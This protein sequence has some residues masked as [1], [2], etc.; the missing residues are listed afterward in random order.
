MHFAAVFI[1]VLFSFIS[2]LRQ[3]AFIMHLTKRIKK[4]PRN[5]NS[6]T[7]NE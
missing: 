4:K 7:F 1:L 2:R 3:D 5:L 6:Q